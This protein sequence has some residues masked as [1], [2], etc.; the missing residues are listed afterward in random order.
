MLTKQQQDEVEKFRAELIDTRVRLREVQANLR[1]DV[2]N[3]GTALKIIDIALMPILVAV[4]ALGLATVRR[5]R[6][7]QARKLG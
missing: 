5:R 1:R 6:R 4:A 2:E 3:L 7:T